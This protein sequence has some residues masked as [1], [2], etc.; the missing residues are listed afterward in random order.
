MT[1]DIIFHVY[2][3]KEGETDHASID[4]TAGG[5][6]VKRKLDSGLASRILKM[7]LADIMPR[8]GLFEEDPKRF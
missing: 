1:N 2:V 6:E 4:L 5:K 8:V 7:C 3:H